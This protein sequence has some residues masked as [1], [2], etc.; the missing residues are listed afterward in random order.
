VA[1]VCF[2]IGNG[3]HSR[4]GDIISIARDGV[5]IPPAEIVAWFQTDTVPTEWALIPGPKQR[6]IR[7]RLVR[8]KWLLDHSVAE[9]VAE[10]RVNAGGAAEMKA[11][12]VID[13]DSYLSV[14]YDSAWG[15]GDLRVHGVARITGFSVQHAMEV[16]EPDM[17]ETYKPVRLGKRRWRIRYRD[18]LSA[19][20]IADLE[21]DTVRV[22]AIRGTPL[23][24]VALYDD[25][26]SA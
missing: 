1:E 6:A 10:F 23:P 22:E 11:N 14:G 4:D 17:T 24:L 26:R 12:A 5:L 7:R 13:R 21:D 8:T 25:P 9:I 16:L 2:R 15:R 18:Y 3:V 19:G 20:M